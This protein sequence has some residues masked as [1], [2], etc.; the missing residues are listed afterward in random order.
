MPK[1]L[2]PS[3][4]RERRTRTRREKEFNAIFHDF[5]LSFGLAKIRFL[6][7]RQSAVPPFVNEAGG[8]KSG[9]AHESGKAF[10]LPEIDS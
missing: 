9:S 1:F 4:R 6:S 7:S 3:S 10:T 2:K 8:L 5:S